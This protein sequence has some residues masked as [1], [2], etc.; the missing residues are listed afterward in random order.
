VIVGRNHLYQ[1][2]TPQI[3]YKTTE[4]FDPEGILGV[5][6][7]V[8]L[9]YLGVQAGRAIIFYKSS[10]HRLALWFVWSL[11]TII[12]YFSLTQFDTNNGFI[13][14]N[15]NLWTFTYTLVTASSSFLIMVIL[16]FIV[17]V[18][19]LW[20]GNPFSFLGMN[21]ILIYVCHAFFATTLPCQWVVS[22]TH[23]AQMLMDLWGSI[24]WTLVAIY[25]Y[26]KNTFINL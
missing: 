6:N 1:K 11:V 9:T 15:K 3:I 13:P 7:S 2:P 21:S 14:V 12:I 26:A 23:L 16:Y 20:N 10:V 4:P 24:F 25:L 8:I 17:D 22:N 5:F 18:K 19:S